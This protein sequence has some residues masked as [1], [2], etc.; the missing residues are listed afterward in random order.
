MTYRSKEKVFNSTQ[1]NIFSKLYEE[2]KLYVF[3]IKFSSRKD[4]LSLEMALKETRPN[5]QDNAHLVPI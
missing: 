1:N 5:K 2:V 3:R 4:K